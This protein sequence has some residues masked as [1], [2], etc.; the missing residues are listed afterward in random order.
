MKPLVSVIIPA[1]NMEKHIKETIDSVLFQTYTNLEIIVVDDGSTDNTAAIVKFIKD[2]RLKYYYQPNSGLPAKPRNK[3]VELS[4]GEYI[5]FLDHDDLWMKNKLEEQMAIMQK[6][7]ILALVSTNAFFILDDTKTRTPMIKGL[8]SGYFNDK[9]FL[10]EIHIIQSTVL[11]RKSVFIEMQGFDESP[12]LKARED[13][14]LWLRTYPK[15][16]FYHLNECL[17]YYRKY[18]SSTSG[19]EL[20]FVE[21]S[22]DHYEKYFARYGFSKRINNKKLSS[23]LHH[24]ACLQYLSGDERY[25]E[26][27]RKAYQLNNSMPNLLLFLFFLP[28]RKYTVNIYRLRKSF[29][30][31]VSCFC[32]NNSKE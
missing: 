13:Y 8:K 9:L 18:D 16:P 27:A 17:A 32:R 2:S 7:P 26:N 31:H 23:I 5:A 21:R 24:L 10:P 30:D 22:L 20:D 3:G 25:R 6:K 14:D 29:L 28:P 11:M 12:D 15:Y 4:R 1:F 19:N